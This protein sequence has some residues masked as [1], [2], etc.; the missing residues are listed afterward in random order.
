MIFKGDM[1]QSDI[2]VPVCF[3]LGFFCGGGG[4]GGGGGGDS[5]PKVCMI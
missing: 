4:G 5:L 2:V 3:G 1:Y